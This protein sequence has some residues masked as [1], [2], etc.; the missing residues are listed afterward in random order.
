MRR[1]I[2][3]SGDGF[4][5]AKHGSI[6][7][8]TDELLIAGHQTGSPLMQ[9]AEIVLKG[10]ETALPE[11][12]AYTDKDG[13]VRHRARVRWYLPTEGY[14]LSDYCF[15][16]AEGADVPLPS[17]CSTRPSLI[18]PTL[19]RYSSDTTGCGP[20]LLRRG[21]KMSPASITALRKGGTYAPI[22]GMASKPST[23][24][25]SCGSIPDINARGGRG[26]HPCERDHASRR[27]VNLHA[28]A[29]NHTPPDTYFRLPRP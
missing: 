15:G 21:R 2:E 9:A 10:K 7:R 29:W 1:L 28:R 19:L 27:L 13:T 3:F 17:G 12:I 22:A 23:A 25:A 26:L 6:P 14:L 5:G 24:T 18:P 11:G 4:S 16:D 8:A 20:S